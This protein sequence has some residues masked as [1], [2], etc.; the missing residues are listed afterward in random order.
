MDRIA[1]L[2]KE[3]RDRDFIETNAAGEQVRHVKSIAAL[4]A[5]RSITRR[6]LYKKLFTAGLGSSPSRISPALTRS[7]RAV[8][9]TSLGFAAATNH[10]RD[11]VNSDCILV[12][13][14]TWP[15]RTRSV[16]TWPVAAQHRVPC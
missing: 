9:G 14:R 10:P 5:R 11:L 1:R 7:V 8:L 15:N 3:C 16:F 6:L 2:V 12:M 4:A 13:V